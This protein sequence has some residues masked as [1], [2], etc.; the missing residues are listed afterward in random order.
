[1]EQENTRKNELFDGTEFSPEFQ[2]ALKNFLRKRYRSSGGAIPGLLAG[3]QVSIPHG[4]GIKPT[5]V[6]LDGYTSDHEMYEYQAAD[7]VNIYIQNGSSVAASGGFWFA[8]YIAN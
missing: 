2:L 5:S 7:D 4:L 1:M 3:H 8:N 6:S